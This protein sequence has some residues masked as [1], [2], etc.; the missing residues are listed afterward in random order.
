MALSRRP[1]LSCLHVRY[2]PAMSAEPAAPAPLRMSEE[3]FLAR[4]ADLK[5]SYEFVNGEVSQKPMPKRD[6]F[7]IQ[8]E[9]AGALRAYR[10]RV[11]GISGAE[12]TVNVSKFR[13]RRYRAPD[14]AY[15][16]PGKV[17]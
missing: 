15:W 5:P 2:T 13:D 9:I 4:Y 12:P 3:E 10:K 8:D 1:G 6:H 14:A 7:F 16:A 17:P 11:G